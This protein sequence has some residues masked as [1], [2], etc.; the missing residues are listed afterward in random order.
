MDQRP[1]DETLP[2]GTTLRLLLARCACPPERLTS[3]QAVLPLAEQ[4]V[5]ACEMTPL[6]YAGHDFA[7][8]GHSLCLIL[9]E[10]HLAIHTYPE[11]ARA[12]IA[13]LS[14]CDHL[15][16]NR[17]RALRLAGLLLEIFQ[18]EEHVLEQAEMVPVGPRRQ[19]CRP[20]TVGL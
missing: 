18:P 20:R 6:T 10:S 16:D 15:R 9:A 5:R 19:G 4:A 13:E 14:V 12:V 2:T 17:A 1:T 11:H 8:A 7:G 3:H